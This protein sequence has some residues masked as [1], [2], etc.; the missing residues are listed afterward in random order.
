VAPPTPPLDQQNAIYQWT[1][2]FGRPRWIDGRGYTRA[3][4]TLADRQALRPNIDIAKGSLVL[5]ADTADLWY[6]DGAAWGRY[7]DAGTF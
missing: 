1:P 4:A 6:F 5:Q 3:V 2:G 7:L